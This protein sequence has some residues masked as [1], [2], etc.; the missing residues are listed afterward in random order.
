[1]KRRIHKSTL[2]DEKAQHNTESL[3]GV[4]TQHKQNPMIDDD[5]HASFKS[6]SSGKEKKNI[7]KI[8]KREGG[9]GVVAVAA[10]FEEN[11][12]EKK[13]NL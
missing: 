4:L 5:S 11:P 12:K 3:L 2:N 7:K 1:M 6:Q 9:G 10:A 13:E 8:P